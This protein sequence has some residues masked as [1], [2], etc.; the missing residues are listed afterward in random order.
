M[1]GS[2]LALQNTPPC[3]YFCELA[4]EEMYGSICQTPVPWIDVSALTP[5]DS[6][7]CRY[8]F[9]LQQLCSPR[10]VNTQCTFLPL[11]ST[12]NSALTKG[13]GSPSPFIDCLFVCVS[14]ITQT[15]LATV[16][17]STLTGFQQSI[18]FICMLIGQP[19]GQSQNVFQFAVILDY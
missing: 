10:M 5:Y 18:L 14:A 12:F 1:T 13:D 17:L 8:H 3:I 11:P 15:G 16:N 7:A 9:F 4:V 19:V 6:N 2:L